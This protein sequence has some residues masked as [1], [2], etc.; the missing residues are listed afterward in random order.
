MKGIVLDL[1]KYRLIMQRF[2]D[3]CHFVFNQVHKTAK[4][5]HKE[6]V[7]G[8]VGY[9]Q[10][11]HVFQYNWKPGT[12]K[13]VSIGIATEMKDLSGSGMIQVFFSEQN[14]GWE[15]YEIKCPFLGKQ[16]FHGRTEKI[17]LKTKTFLC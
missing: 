5:S 15:R 9:S 11:V 6:A 17:S 4:S 3:L 7:L 16:Y 2:K 13:H 14:T 10:G 8:K 1:I 12:N